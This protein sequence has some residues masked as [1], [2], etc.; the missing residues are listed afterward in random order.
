MTLFTPCSDSLEM[1]DCANL[2]ASNETGFNLS[3]RASRASGRRGTSTDSAACPNLACRAQRKPRAPARPL[4]ACFDLSAITALSEASVASIFT[5]SASESLSMMA[6]HSAAR[7]S[8][9]E[10]ARS[11]VVSMVAMVLLVWVRLCVRRRVC[12][13]PGV[14]L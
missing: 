12:R 4:A 7:S 8:G 11:L 5:R 2:S 14:R 10:V 9:V 3:A 6:L 13:R 1:S